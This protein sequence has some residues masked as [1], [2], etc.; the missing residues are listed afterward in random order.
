MSDTTGNI[1][2]TVKLQLEDYLA[3]HRESAMNRNKG[4]LIVYS[5]IF[6]I[7]L[8]Y[9]FANND[10]KDNFKLTIITGLVVLGVSIGAMYFSTF[11]MRGVIKRNYESDPQVRSEQVHVFSKEGLE[12]S[13]STSNVKYFWQDVYRVRETS[14]YF[15]IYVAMSKAFIVPRTDLDNEKVVSE[16][17]DLLIE[18]VPDKKLQLMD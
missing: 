11:L 4:R 9:A 18:N 13:S 5:I 3:F 12:V 6:F 15:F 7:L 10:W 14:K 16:L 8:L 2:V 1:S 17:K